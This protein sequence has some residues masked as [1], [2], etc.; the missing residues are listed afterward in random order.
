LVSITSLQ[1]LAE[2]FKQLKENLKSARNKQ[3]IFANRHRIKA[4][5]FKANDKVWVN[6][7]LLI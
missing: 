2:L 6:S 7:S 1:D 4:P 3:E 5:E